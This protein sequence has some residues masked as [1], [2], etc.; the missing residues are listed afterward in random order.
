MPLLHL[1][2]HRLL[3][4]QRSCRSTALTLS[5]GILSILALTTSNLATNSLTSKVGLLIRHPPSRLL[6][7]L[8]PCATPA[9]CATP[10][11]YLPLTPNFTNFFATSFPFPLSSPLP[12]ALSWPLLPAQL[13]L[14]NLTLFQHLLSSLPFGTCPKGEQQQEPCDDPTLCLPCA[15]LWD[16]HTLHTL[17][18]EH[19]SFS[20]LVFVGLAPYFDFLGNSNNTRTPFSSP[21]LSTALSFSHLLLYNV[22]TSPIHALEGQTALAQAL[23]GPSFTL[24]LTLRDYPIEPPFFAAFDAF[25]S[26]GAQFTSFSVAFLFFEFLSAMVREKELGY[27]EALG[28]AG[29]GFGPYW[30]QWG[31]YLGGFSFL[32]SLLLTLAGVAASLPFFTRAPFVVVFLVFFASHWSLGGLAALLSSVIDSSV[33]ATQ[34]GWGASIVF[35][36]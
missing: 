9:D 2:K 13:T 5:I 22:S 20:R 3:L 32:T 33:L 25:S 17:L 34:A 19:P 12:K 29:M 31:V 26:S 27:V 28:I 1:L 15:L 23:L 8:H 4:L 11:L 24:N 21:S 18:L 30:G 7:S 35:F 10:L 6:H 16:N 36:T 14:V